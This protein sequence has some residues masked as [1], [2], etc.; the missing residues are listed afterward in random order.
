MMIELQLRP[1]T[2]G[3][4]LGRTNAYQSTRQGASRMFGGKSRIA[5]SSSLGLRLSDENDPVAVDRAPGENANENG[6][7]YGR[8][9]A[10]TKNKAPKLRVRVCERW[11]STIDLRSGFCEDLRQ[12]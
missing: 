8:R 1:L 5:A 10:A 6:K 2:T 9:A 3:L 11:R 4:G 7:S 12:E